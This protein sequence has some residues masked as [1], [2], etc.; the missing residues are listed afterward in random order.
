MAAGS[1][2]DQALCIILLKSEMK[3]PMRMGI[4][5]ITSKNFDLYLER[6]PSSDQRNN[7]KPITNRSKFAVFDKL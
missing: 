5:V 2:T 7:P 4:S 1:Y 6:F 3:L